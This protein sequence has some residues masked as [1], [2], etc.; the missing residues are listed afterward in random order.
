M[1]V[2]SVLEKFSKLKEN[3]KRQNKAWEFFPSDFIFVAFL[4][5]FKVFKP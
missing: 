2:R 3:I 1:S 5:F 4:L